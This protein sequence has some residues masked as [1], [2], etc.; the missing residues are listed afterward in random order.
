MFMSG[1]RGRREDLLPAFGHEEIRWE[2][3]GRVSSSEMCLQTE[4]TSA[5]PPGSR[6]GLH[7]DSDLL[8]EASLK[9]N[10]NG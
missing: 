10:E 7:G 9:S 6:P 8:L 5:C 4:G 2:S 1:G 3:Q